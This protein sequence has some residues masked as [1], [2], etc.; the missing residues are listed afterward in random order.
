MK[1]YKQVGVGGEG[2]VWVWVGVGWV[3]WGWG[4]C[5]AVLN[6]NRTERR[7]TENETRSYLCVLSLYLSVTTTRTVT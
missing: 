1:K 4:G 7:Q 6:V 3:E 5:K 2:C